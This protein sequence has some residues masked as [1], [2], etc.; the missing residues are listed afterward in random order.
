MRIAVRTITALVCAMLAM[1]FA[2]CDGAGPAAPTHGVT[3]SS[4][5]PGALRVDNEIDYDLKLADP[6]YAVSVY[7]PR[8]LG[9]IDAS[10]GET[11]SVGGMSVRLMIGLPHADGAGPE[12]WNI[13]IA[14]N[15]DVRRVATVYAAHKRSVSLIALDTGCDGFDTSDLFV[16]FD[17]PYSNTTYRY[18]EP[19]IAHNGRIAAADY[20]A[21]TLASRETIAGTRYMYVNYRLDAL[22]MERVEEESYTISS[23]FLSQERE[24]EFKILGQLTLHLPGGLSETIERGWTIDQFLPPLPYTP[25]IVRVRVRDW[26]D[27]NTFVDGLVDYDALTNGRI[28]S[29]DPTVL[30]YCVLKRDLPADVLTG[31][32]YYEEILLASGTRVRFESYAPGPPS[33]IYFSTYAG[34]AGRFSHSPDSDSISGVDARDALHG[35]L[36]TD[37]I[38]AP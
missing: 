25:R 7:N 24:Y 4:D 35:V 21:L 34:E 1:C 9:I 5:N 23:H 16:A 11:V 28:T 10:A 19:D 36:Y 27:P 12:M 31:S 30:E 37:V 32:G 13:Y 17:E 33:Y 18:T 38:S 26:K 8:G 3:H 20:N 22:T 14:V 6:P 15:G 29:A 2:A